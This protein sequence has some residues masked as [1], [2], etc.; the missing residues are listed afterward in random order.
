MPGSKKEKNQKKNN[1]TANTAKKSSTSSKSSKKNNTKNGK[2]IKTS[3][4]VGVKERPVISSEEYQ[5]K[6]KIKT[7]V[8]ILVTIA[9]CTCL[10]LSNFALLGP[11]GSFIANY[12]FGF[13]GILAYVFP[14]ILLGFVIAALV[15]KKSVFNYVVKAVLACILI[16]LLASIIQLSLGKADRDTT[17]LG[18]FALS[19]VSKNGGGMLGG[20]L[21]SVLLPSIDTVGTYVILISALLLFTM[22]F[23]GRTLFTG[24]G[25]ATKNAI[26]N[27]KKMTSEEDETDED[28]EEDSSIFKNSKNSKDYF[29]SVSKKQKKKFK[30]QRKAFNKEQADLRKH[31][32]NQYDEDTILIP[33]EDGY[34][35]DELSN[36]LNRVEEEKRN[37]LREKI[38]SMEGQEE[39]KRNFLGGYSSTTPYRVSDKYENKEVFGPDV[40]HEAATADVI[41]SS[42]FVNINSEVQKE[43][44]SYP[45]PSEITKVVFG[46]GRNENKIEKDTTLETEDSGKMGNL[47][48]TSLSSTAFEND[49]EE[50][51]RETDIHEEM[52]E[53]TRSTTVERNTADRGDFEARLA[54]LNRRKE[55]K[56]FNNMKAKKKKRHHGDDEDDELLNS[57]DISWE[58]AKQNDNFEAASEFVDTE[59]KNYEKQ[60]AD[61][62]NSSDILNMYFS[63]DGKNNSAEYDN[64]NENYDDT[65]PE[66]VSDEASEEKSFE[67][68]NQ[69]QNFSSYED[70]YEETES[71]YEASLS[72]NDEAYLND[73]YSNDEYSNETY[74]GEA[75][76]NENYVNDSNHD[77]YINQSEDDKLSV[78][79][80]DDNMSNHGYVEP[81]FENEELVFSDSRL[82]DM[83][84]A[85][86]VSK[87]A[88]EEFERKPFSADLS[89]T[90]R[91]TVLR[92][93]QEAQEIF[94]QEHVKPNYQVTIPEYIE[95]KQDIITEVKPVKPYV[96]PPIDLLNPPKTNVQRASEEELNATAESLKSTLESFNVHVTINNISVGPSITR[97]E[98]QPEQG[99]KV[100]RITALA[101]DIKLN[102]AAS[103]IR[104]EAPIPG[105]AAVG[106]EVP[107]KYSTMVTLREILDAPEFKNHLS[108]VSFGVGKD[109]AGMNI[110]GDVSKMPHTLIAGATGSGKSVCINTILIS[111]LYKASSEDVKFIMIDPKM[112]ELSVYNGIPHLLDRVVTD[113][114]KAANA[115]NWA[116]DEMNK[117]YAKFAD[118]SVRDIKGYN[119]YV[120]RNNAL[121]GTTKKE[122]L[123]QIVIVIDEL[124]DLMAVCQSDVEVAICR[125]AQMARAAGMFL[126][127]ATQRP[128]VNVITGLIKAN[129]PSRIAFAVSSQVDS[130]TILDQVGAE[131][132]LGKGDMLYYPTGMPKPVRL[133]GA[134]VSDDEVNRVVDFIRKNNADYVKSNTEVSDRINKV[135]KSGSQSSFTEEIEDELDELFEI[136]GKDIIKSQK[137]SIGNLQR[138]Y[139][140]GFN[141][142]SR[143]MSQLA[144]AKV[145]GPEEGKKPREVLMTL[146]EFEAYLDEFR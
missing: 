143:I 101:D 31:D 129:V 26:E 108:K 146:D 10:F 98:I 49:V 51:D 126:I 116:V 94:S 77:T 118:A 19:V 83:A 123:P 70:S 69:R 16:M 13:F 47:S 36:I 63:F 114:K 61:S 35:E 18:Y 25:G 73:N 38:K 2:P 54:S 28:D 104:I 7:E 1:K 23:S 124:S 95:N 137:A 92:N 85:Q 84:I 97:F 50:I 78:E 3:R 102:L 121:P 67:S 60:Y 55:M 128:S 68:D 71:R 66:T 74:S 41:P 72:N 110:V 115:L 30:K 127:I 37:K 34:D 59:D 8:V 62:S 17:V 39:N 86:A 14:F 87:E 135:A 52:Q 65:I 117:R 99:V 11:F 56:A 113:P 27:R 133:Q 106:I 82:R 122:K 93:R 89:E 15:T 5:K 134:Y 46:H 90:A 42:E 33:E 53:N 58:E 4:V 100:A 24:L 64:D 145:V 132:L 81:D 125:L 43:S 29:A 88:K 139:R 141:R 9:I 91:E 80:T 57:L 112:V 144:D 40:M 6:K 21:L 105:K 12:T 130:R 79:I 44:I 142:A 111:I 109:I 120:E 138:A 131:K 20:L 103:D 32:R 76:S 136:A 96:L 140:I 119:D 48:D 107:N 75:Y 22:L 45:K